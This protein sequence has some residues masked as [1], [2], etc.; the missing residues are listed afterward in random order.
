MA[1]EKLETFL[2]RNNV[3][4]DSNLKDRIAIDLDLNGR[5]I[6]TTFQQRQ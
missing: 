1:I 6:K 4:F 2:K 5:L 3:K